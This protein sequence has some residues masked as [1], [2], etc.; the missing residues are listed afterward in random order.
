MT[1]RRKIA[2]G[3]KNRHTREGGYPGI[4]TT[5]YELIR[6]SLGAK[7]RFGVAKR[8]R[9]AIMPLLRNVNSILIVNRKTP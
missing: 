2:K 3:Y 1:K 8:K 5:F 9:F 4:R 7:F 6:L